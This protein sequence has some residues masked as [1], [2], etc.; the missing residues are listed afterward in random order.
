MLVHTVRKN[1]DIIPGLVEHQQPLKDIKGLQKI[2]FH[3]VKQLS[4]PADEVD[5][6]FEDAKT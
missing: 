4:Q 6:I 3:T 1:S 5:S 2:K